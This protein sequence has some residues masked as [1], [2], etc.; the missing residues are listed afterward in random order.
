MAGEEG[1]NMRFW[2]PGGPSPAALV[3]L[4]S[5]CRE[6]DRAGAQSLKDHN[7]VCC[8]WIM[9]LPLALHCQTQWRVA[10][11]HVAVEWPGSSMVLHSCTDVR[12]QAATGLAPRPR[13][14]LRCCSS[15]IIPSETLF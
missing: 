7:W 6:L 1:G 14:S 13:S 9:L 4:L 2:L 11:T 10:D 3:A 12:L 5:A 8:Y 15:A